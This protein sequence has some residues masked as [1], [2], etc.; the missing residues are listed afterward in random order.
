MVVILKMEVIC[1]LS[2]VVLIDEFYGGFL[3]CCVLYLL[4][5][6]LFKFVDDLSCVFNFD[7]FVN[8]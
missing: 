6:I 8:L 4:R 3:F 2:L 1:E 5:V 7:I